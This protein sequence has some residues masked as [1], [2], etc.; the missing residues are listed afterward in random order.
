MWLRCC[1]GGPTGGFG[2]NA[3]VPLIK[4]NVGGSC[5]V[6]TSLPRQILRVGDAN[7][8]AIEVLHPCTDSRSKQ[9]GEGLVVMGGDDG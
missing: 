2:S 4:V 7:A 1:S 8:V 5:L 9:P 6:V 3:S